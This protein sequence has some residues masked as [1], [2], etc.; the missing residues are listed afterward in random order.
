MRIN[1]VEWIS[2]NNYGKPKWHSHML[3]F[4]WKG[5]FFF[6]FFLYFGLDIV[7]HNVQ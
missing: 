1:R 2:A 4:N 5:F 3:S 7:S 6:F